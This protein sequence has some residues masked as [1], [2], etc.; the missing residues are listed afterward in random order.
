LERG[1]PHHVNAVRLT[2]GSWVRPH[3]GAGGLREAASD[4][5]HLGSGKR[6]PF[7]RPPRNRSWRPSSHS[8]GI[9][10][11]TPCS[12]A[13]RRRQRCQRQPLERAR[14][15]KTPSRKRISGCRSGSRAVKRD[16][17]QPRSHRAAPSF[18]VTSPRVFGRA[19]R[20][21]KEDFSRERARAARLGR[22]ASTRA[23]R[24]ASRGYSSLRWE[25]AEQG[26]SSWKFRSAEVDRTHRR[27]RRPWALP[28]APRTRAT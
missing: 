6:T 25:A 27:S 20:G 11:A 5:R 13:R 15:K 26:C 2:K 21:A 3:F 12:R 16:S 7:T 28:S 17:P 24:K 14:R 19:E 8:V 23:R 10:S 4:G 18:P 22:R 9:A 1:D